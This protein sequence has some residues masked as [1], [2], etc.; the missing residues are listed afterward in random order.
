MSAT[1]VTE[2]PTRRAPNG[3]VPARRAVIRWALRLLRREWRQQLLILALITVAVGATVVAATV[4]TDTP[5]PIAAVLGTAQDAAS[6]TGPPA[7]INAEITRI[8]S[9][10]GQTDVIE[11][12]TAPVP[13]TQNTFDLRAQNTRGP[14]G[15]PLL[16]LVSGQYPATANEIAVTGGVA[17]DFH[18]TIGS[19]WTVAG[20]TWKVTGIVANPQSLLDEFALVLPGQVTNPSDATVLFDAPGTASAVENATAPARHHR[21]DGGQRQRDQPRDDLG[22]RGRPRHAADR[23][24]G[25]RRLHG[26]RPA[27]AQGDRHARRPGRHRAEHQ[28]RR[29]GQRPG[30]RRGRRGGG[31]GAR[32][33]AMA[34][35]PPAGGEQRAP[36]DG[37]V[38]AAVDG[39]R[40]LDGPRDHRDLLRRLPA[41]QGH[42]ENPDRG[43]AG[44]APARAEE[45]PPLG[46][47]GRRLLPHW[48]VPPARR[49]R[50]GDR[51]RC[52]RW[53]PGKRDV[54]NRPRLRRA[55]R[56]HRAAGPGAAFGG[57]RRR[58]ARPDRGQARAQGPR[59]VPGQIRPGA[60]GDQ[61]QHADRGHHLR[62]ERRPVRQ[63][64]R[65][66]RPQPHLQP[67]HRLRAGRELPARPG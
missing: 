49:G 25:H 51:G 43:G 32:L 66:R 63:R 50:R 42:R 31:A 58:Q 28:A 19:S 46:G 36:R 56:R 60:R 53:E 8:E 10:Y 37:R 12:E 21:A 65:L 59:P 18:L 22:R 47:P 48:R 11:N 17:A 62:G 9:L 41:R 20:Q 35:L 54:G 24:G 23:A 57:R 44:R 13:G 64:P 26:P 27:P 39:H 1:A 16:S 2:R 30:D 5:A 15:G 40:H 61:P 45:D 7:T 4:A 52:G 3:G 38:P 33:P 14:F 67:A 34:R 6:I 55:R 29:A